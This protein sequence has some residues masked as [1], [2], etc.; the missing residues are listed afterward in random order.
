[1]ETHHIIHKI[2]LFLYI[3]IIQFPGGLYIPI[4]KDIS[5]S[6]LNKLQVSNRIITCI[7]RDETD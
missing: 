7:I 2:S 6:Y 4:Q 5:M 3:E 1:V